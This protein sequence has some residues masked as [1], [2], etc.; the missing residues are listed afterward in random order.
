MFHAKGFTIVELLVVIVVIGILSALSVVAFN[1][2]QA[3]ARE[4]TVKADA[5]NFLKKMEVAKV[6][7]S[8]YP[9][10]TTISGNDE[11][12]LRT[13]LQNAG[14]R[15]S[16]DSYDQVLYCVSNNADKY[17]M[18]VKMRNNGRTYAYGSDRAFSEYTTYAIA[19]Y[20]DVC[21][22]LIGA[23]DWT[24]YSGRQTFGYDTT[25]SVWRAWTGQ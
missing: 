12:Q 4:S 21:N 6:T 22:S 24:S 14:L 20:D 19:F 17:A 8:R 1:G 2:V 25:N 11:T 3:R 18:V 9:S 13:S 16:K 23:A 5:S 7:D 15:L 10:P